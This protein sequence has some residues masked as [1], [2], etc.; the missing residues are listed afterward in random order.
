MQLRYKPYAVGECGE[1]D[2]REASFEDHLE[3]ISLVVAITVLLLGMLC[4]ALVASPLFIGVITLLLEGT[5]ILYGLH[6]VL[7]RKS[8]TYRNMARIVPAFQAQ[9]EEIEDEI[10]EAQQGPRGP[11]TRVQV[12]PLGEI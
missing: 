12:Y 8:G 10:G 5:L 9:I 7:L 3:T 6:G 4:R 1:I 11:T 2:E